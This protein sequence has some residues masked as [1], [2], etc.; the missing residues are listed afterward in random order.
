MRILNECKILLLSVV[1][2]GL[3][4]ADAAEGGP[5]V[6]FSLREAERQ[7]KQ[8]VGSSSE[9]TQM[10]GITRL[11]ALVHDPEHEDLIIVGQVNENEAQTNLDDFVVALRAR[12]TYDGWPEVSIERTGSTEETG[13]QEVR[14]EAGIADT[15]FG[16]DLLDA[17]VILKKMAFGLVPTDIWGIRPY[18]AMAAERAKESARQRTMSTRFWFYPMTVDVAEREGVVVI[19]DLKVGVRAQVLAASDGGN[20][21]EDVS[22]MKNELAETFASAI[23]G[24]YGDLASSYPSVSRVKLLLDLVA[25]AHGIKC[26][27]VKTDMRFWLQ[28]YKVTRVDTAKDYPLLRQN[29]KMSANGEEYEWE[30]EGGVRLEVYL[31]RLNEDGDLTAI[32]DLVLK[33]RPE[34][35]RVTWPVPLE[36]WQIYGDSKTE[37]QER[38]SDGAHSEDAPVQREIGMSLTERVL[39]P[40]TPRSVREPAQGFSSAPLQQGMPEFRFSNRLQPQGLSSNV[41]GVLLQGA[42]K[43][44]GAAEAR[45]NLNSGSFSLVV[46]G[47]SA[48]L[49]QEAFRKF[50]TALWAVYYGD[51]D[52]GISIDPIA[53]G[54]KK[55]M[56]RYIGKV[57]NS[58]LGRVMREADY[59]MKQWAVGTSRPDIPGFQNP[60]DIAARNRVVYVGAAS[61]FWFVPQD[62]RFRRAG[63]LLLFENGRMVVKTEFLFNNDSMHADPANERFAQFF[64]DR[65]T[66]I[67]RK[68]PV[69]NELFEYA[70]MVSLAKYLKDSG[71]PLFWFLMA[72]KDL[73]LTEDSPGTVDALAKGSDYFKNVSIEGGVDLAT[74]GHYVYDTEAVEAINEAISK[75]RPTAAMETSL[76]TSEVSRSISDRFSFDLSGQAYSVLPQHSLTC[77]RDRRGIRYQTDIAFR[78]AG[79]CLTEQTLEELDARITRMFMAEEA[80]R[81]AQPSKGASEEQIHRWRQ[82]LYEQA[83][84][85]AKPI[86]ESLNK[87]K[88]QK[89]SSEQEFA[90]AVDTVLPAREEADWI[91]PMVV[92][93]GYYN[94]LLE[95]VR[96][97]NPRQRGCG[98]FGEGWRLMIPY[99]IHPADQAKKEFNNALVPERMTVQNLVTGDSETLT[100]SADRYSVAGYVPDNIGKSQ[101]IGLFLMAD[102]SFRLAD[103]LGDEF[104]FDPAGRLTDMAFSDQYR[105]HVEY[106]DDFTDQFDQPPYRVERASEE[107]VEV[108]RVPLPTTMAVVDNIRGTREAMVFDPTGSIVGYVP[109]NQAKTR[110][111]IL[112]VLSDRSFR[113]L[114][115]AGNEVA[116]GPDGSFKGMSLSSDTLVVRSIG[117]GPY[118]VDFGYTM[119]PSGSP[120][121]ARARL[122][123]QDAPGT[124][125]A[126]RYEYDDE[127]RLCR[128]RQQDVQVAAAR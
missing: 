90:Q 103:K 123:K 94:T 74:Q 2:A 87:L 63:D 93:Q 48:R 43:V 119:A 19:N 57:I 64:T 56:V 62:M 18:S 122:S 113:L 72:N 88:G 11:A 101:V 9:I 16:K 44:E 84:E 102:T 37:I 114:D 25:L 120:L 22:K 7:L 53:P 36:G 65:Y 27:P 67:A 106:A 79:F 6:A 60:D 104:W 61:R 1:V 116:F 92:K 73:V 29:Q 50:V 35:A 108:Q 41:G 77:G 10:G 32:R 105:T 15:Q 45:V 66:E 125:Y 117:V 95:L 111:Q 68:Y 24:S 69:Y 51:R 107:R 8:A 112:A 4:P 71:V 91:K 49:S 85:R 86:Q 31:S 23:T 78:D 96:Y 14:F 100:F 17:D 42:A 82:S 97:F 118:K 26:L 58:D 55:H 12:L 38:T 115:K 124:L 39:P 127:N 46:D 75:S 52:P 47:K 30:L 33:T 98:D 89:Y 54:V 81:S 5:F 121:V 109:R 34:G 28:D 13:K 110:F 21:I 3:F 80:S 59:L 128:V 76:G 20:H 126:V 40:G 83:V 70:K 99:R